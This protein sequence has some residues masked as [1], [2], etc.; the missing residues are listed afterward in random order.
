[1]KVIESEHSKRMP[2]CVRPLPDLRTGAIL[3]LAILASLLVGMVCINYSQP[4]EI[5][6][7]VYQALA[8]MGIGRLIYR[9][10][11]VLVIVGWLFTVIL[12]VIIVVITMYA[13]LLFQWVTKT[14]Y[15]VSFPPFC[16]ITWILLFVIWWGGLSPFFKDEPEKRSFLRR[17]MLF[18]LMPIININMYFMA[19]HH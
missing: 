10:S 1:M 13:I 12:P 7:P 15:Y 6:I 18:V 2:H 16:L 5:G 8:I 14:E 3:W 19:M 4:A 17:L 9:V 11:W